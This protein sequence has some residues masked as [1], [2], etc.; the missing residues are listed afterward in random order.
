MSYLFWSLV[1]FVAR[2]LFSLRYRVKTQGCFE[3]LNEKLEGG[4]LILPNHTAHMD[5]LLLFCFF[6]PKFRM[7]PLVIE[8]IYRMGPMQFL[9]HLTRAIAVPDFDTSV[10]QYKIYK[11]QKALETVADGLKKGENFILY[12]SGRLKS[13]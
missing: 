7:R 11:A 6:W 1:G 4:I 13:T 9:I 3:V 2:A 5:P 10:N 8:Y 12:P